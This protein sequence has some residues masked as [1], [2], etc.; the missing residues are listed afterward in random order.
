[1]RARLD[2][3]G[4]PGRYTCPAVL[5]AGPSDTARSAPRPAIER[6]LDNLLQQQANGPLPGVAAGWVAGDQFRCEVS[7][8]SPATLRVRR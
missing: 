3:D 1:V 2:A 5:G 6:V 7:P 8:R 4:C